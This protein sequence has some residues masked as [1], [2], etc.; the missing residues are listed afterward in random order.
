MRPTNPITNSAFPIKRSSVETNCLILI[1]EALER[2]D[3]A[4]EV[5]KSPSSQASGGCVMWLSLLL[6]ASQTPQK[7][8]RARQSTDQIEGRNGRPGNEGLAS[9]R[10]YACLHA[11]HFRLL[12]GS[13]LLFGRHH[14][15]GGT[16]LFSGS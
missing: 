14:L 12:L 5:E 10:Q 8:A 7:R 2:G 13:H 15:L 11:G 16:H 1:R 4:W 6:P 3:E 9:Q